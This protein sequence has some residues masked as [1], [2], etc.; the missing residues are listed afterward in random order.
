MA[1][2][3][4]AKKVAAKYGATLVDDKAGNTHECR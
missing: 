4:A 1:T 2:L 3:A